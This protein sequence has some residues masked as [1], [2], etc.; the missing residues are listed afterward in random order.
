M[1]RK[2]LLAGL[3]FLLLSVYIY[4]STSKSKKKDSSDI[5][6]YDESDFESSKKR[7]AR[8]QKSLFDED[9]KF[10]EF[11]GGPDFEIKGEYT[12]EELAERKK[13]IIEKSKYLADLFPNNS[14]IPRLLSK[15]EEKEKM[16]IEKK[17]SEVRNKFLNGL[18]TNKEERHFYYTNRLKITEDRLEIFK[19]VLGK[20]SESGFDKD[21]LE[22]ILKERFDDM[23]ELEKAYKE[24]I[25]KNE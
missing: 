15:K 21:K 4:F 16:E 6:Y 19:F 9:S 3:A 8:I 1:K 24:E 13:L 17:M 10:L 2:Y 5:S 12:E 25:K 20:N 7:K 11:Q 18:E 22:P 23:T 14:V